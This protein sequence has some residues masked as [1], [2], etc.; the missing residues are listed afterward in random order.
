L[1]GCPTRRRSPLPLFLASL[2]VLPLSLLLASC[3]PKPA[4]PPSP[5]FRPD[6]VDRLIERFK[7]QEGRVSTLIVSGR[8]SL[9]QKD[10][11]Q[12][13]DLLAVAI[14]DPLRIKMELTHPWGRPLF[15]LSIEASNVRIVSFPEKRLYVGDLQ[16]LG[17]WVCLPPGTTQDHL[18]P[19]LRA[20][21]SLCS[22]DRAASL[23]GGQITLFDYEGK[24]VEIIDLYPDTTLPH[25]VSFPGQGLKLTFSGYREDDGISYATEIGLRGDGSE[26][27]LVL[28]L[29]QIVF[30]KAAP[31][32][33]FHLSV[34][35][36]FKTLPL[37]GMDR[38]PGEDSTGNES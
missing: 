3:A 15:H 30:N 16:A 32:P 6:T 26:T 34:P 5:P 37:E 27:E 9:K 23:Q 8:L 13:V 28:H 11:E 38:W 36:S 33:V 21:P 22:H 2:G 19:L 10:R 4:R 18:W 1:K 20:F 7:E 24:A 17:R 29:R 14:R 35:E 12:E 25:R 31:E